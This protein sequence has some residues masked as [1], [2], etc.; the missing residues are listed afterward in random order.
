MSDGGF[1]VD[2]DRGAICGSVGGDG[3]ELVLLHGGPGLSDYTELLDGET[4]DWRTVRYQQRGLAPS[5][6]EGPFDVDRHVTDAAAVL[7]AVVVDKA[8]L[9]GHS[10]GAHLA[11]QVA[12]ALPERVLAVVAVD[13]LGPA[14]DG[15][16]T[17]FGAELRRRTAPNS[18]TRLNEIDARPPG[19]EVTDAEAL[20]S[21]ALVWPAYFADPSSAPPMPP[22][23]RLSARCSSATFE[24]VLRQLG[25]E[26]FAR[27]LAHLDVP[28]VTVVGGSSPMP[29]SVAEEMTAL[30]P[31]GDLV[32]VPGAGHLPWH[33]Q[34][35]CIANVLAALRPLV[36]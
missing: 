28:V 27:R 30:L 18:L 9:L 33:E 11:L 10:W 6:L 4:S 16:A 12:L 19:Q 3:P 31:Q 13:G 8:V 20:E 26:S 2:T 22:D 7:E 24:S 34:P 15:G 29:T 36:V 1:T 14:G 5:S 35:G 21:L 17:A 25:D 32:V 23:L